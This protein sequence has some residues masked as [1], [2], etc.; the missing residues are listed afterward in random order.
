MLAH[1]CSK[2]EITEFEQFAR[3]DRVHEVLFSRIAPN[4]YGAE[5]IKRAV[6]CLLFGGARKASACL[7]V[8][9]PPC[10]AK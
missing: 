2:E 7:A 4:I 3:Q 8:H 1:A 10:V 9:L 6:G 5:D